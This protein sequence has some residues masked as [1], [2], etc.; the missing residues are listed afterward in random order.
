VL[1]EEP[2]VVLCYPRSKHI[3]AQG[4]HIDRYYLDDFNFRSSKVDERFRLYIDRFFVKFNPKCNPVFGLMR[5]QVLRKVGG[6]GNYD[7]A[8]MIMLGELLLRGPFYEVPERL[9]YRRVHA[10]SAYNA[11][12]TPLARALWFDP[13]NKGKIGLL[14]WKW[15]QA[16]LAAI[17]RVP[18]TRDERLHCYLQ[19]V[20]WFFIYGISR[21]AY[22]VFVII[23]R[24]TSQPKELQA[25]KEG[26]V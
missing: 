6:L 4:S 16:Y 24:L 23:R 26:A 15:L 8:D 17:K 14:R 13:A 19:I 1:D 25:S 5:T 21:M 22:D 18:M 2:F 9:F 7:S 12:R 3:D 20:R 10:E 11:N